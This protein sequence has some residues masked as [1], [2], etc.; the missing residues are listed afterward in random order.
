LLVG[1]EAVFRRT[2]GVVA[3]AQSP[4]LALIEDQELAFHSNVTFRGHR[5]LLVQRR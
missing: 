3:T 4:D 1:A 2:P 5:Q